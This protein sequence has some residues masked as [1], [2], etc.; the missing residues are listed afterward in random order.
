MIIIGAHPTSTTLLN[1]KQQVVHSTQ[2]RPSSVSYFC[3][4]AVWQWFSKKACRTS[5][6][7]TIS[8]LDRNAN[9]LHLRITESEIRISYSTICF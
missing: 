6:F 3:T 8:K 1:Y 7:S 9:C 2:I 5:S 4:S